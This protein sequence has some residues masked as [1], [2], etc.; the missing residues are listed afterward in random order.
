MST[1]NI[2]VLLTSTIAS[3]DNLVPNTPVLSRI[4]PG[5][6][7][8]GAAATY[9]DEYFQ[10]ALLG[11]NPVNLPTSPCFVVWVRNRDATHNVGITI[12][13]VTIGV[14]QCFIGPG[15]VFLYYNANKNFG[16]TA[17][18]LTGLLGTCLCEV[19]LAG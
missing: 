17:L 15:D 14:S 13:Y 3:Y 9:V 12:T 18:A 7:P 16:F 2:N 1:P 6:L 4:N 8:F 10:A 5:S 19:F 11:A